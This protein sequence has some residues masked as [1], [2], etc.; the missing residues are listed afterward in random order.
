MNGEPHT[1]ALEFTRRWPA[2]DSGMPAVKYGDQ[3][4]HIFWS[5][6]PFY[7]WRLR[8]AARRVIRKHDRESQKA[9]T[10][11]I[12]KKTVQQELAAEFKTQDSDVW[13]SEKLQPVWRR[14]GQ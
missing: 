9:F 4:K 14:N 1:H 11:A 6:V 12:E 5:W 7:K 3:K 10:A 8:L 13:L 2:L